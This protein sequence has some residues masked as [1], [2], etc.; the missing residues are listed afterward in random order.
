LLV[1]IFAERHPEYVKAIALISPIML[2]QKS[3]S[4]MWRASLNS[5][6]EFFPY[7]SIPRRFLP[8]FLTTFE[9]DIES[10][11]SFYF[12]Y[13]LV[14]EFLDELEESDENFSKLSVHTSLFYGSKKSQISYEEICRRINKHDQKELFN[15]YPID[16]DISHP[17]SS[18]V[19]RIESLLS[20]LIPWLEKREK[21]VN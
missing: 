19:E 7:K 1:S 12:S 5:V 2:T 13:Q 14:H 8:D 6:R 21:E 16:D 3:P 15:V 9:R 10:S 17:L 4:F 20:N 18:E 11:K